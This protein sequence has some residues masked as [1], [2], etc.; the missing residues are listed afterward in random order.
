MTKEPKP[1]KPEFDN[2]WIKDRRKAL[3]EMENFMKPKDRLEA[4]NNMISSLVYLG[5][6][7]QGWGQWFSKLNIMNQ[8]SEE[9]LCKLSEEFA[10]Q[11]MEFIKWDVKATG[12]FE[13]PKDMPILDHGLIEDYAR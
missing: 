13:L 6:S 5:Q 7:A 11:V 8:V 10:L 4:L 12:K 3:R 2:A 1:K 9:E